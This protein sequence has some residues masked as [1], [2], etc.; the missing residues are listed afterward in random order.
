MFDMT[1]FSVFKDID[2]QSF[3]QNIVFC[4]CALSTTSVISK[5]AI[6]QI[7]RIAWLL[8]IMWNNRGIILIP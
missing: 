1:L 2:A 3:S 8:R 6:E 4:C 5:E 7:T